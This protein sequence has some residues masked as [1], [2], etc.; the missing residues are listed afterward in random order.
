MVYNLLK[1]CDYNLS[2][3]Y[4]LDIVLGIIGIIIY[5]YESL[6]DTSWKKSIFLDGVV[7]F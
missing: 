2:V 7:Y 3:T 4:L 1:I 5:D 6:L